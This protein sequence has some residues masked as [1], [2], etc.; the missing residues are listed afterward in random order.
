M[1]NQYEKYELV[2]GVNMFQNGSN[3][4]RAICYQDEDLLG[5]ANRS[6][7]NGLRRSL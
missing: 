4:S 2:R 5:H 3:L 7:V 1:A 6:L